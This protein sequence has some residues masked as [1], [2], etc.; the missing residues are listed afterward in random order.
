MTPQL[1]IFGLNIIVISLFLALYGLMSGVNSL[2]GVASSLGVLGGVFIV[3]SRIPRDPTITA[4]VNYSKYFLNQLRVLLKTLIYWIQIYV[5]L[6]KEMNCWAVYSKIP[7][8]IQ[9][10]PGVGFTGGSPYLA[11]PI[12]IPLVEGFEATGTVDQATLERMLR[13]IIVDELGMARELGLTIT[14]NTYHVY[15]HGLIEVLKDY[16]KY[17]VDPYVIVTAAII[18]YTTS[19]SS[20]RVVEKTTTPD[21]V[22]IALRA[23]EIAE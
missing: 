3:Y 20:I 12:E 4:L 1:F 6:E 14:G 23:G 2:I 10:D 18:A 22:V 7:C 8:P 5:L 13:T 11:I 17:P 9:V 19:A 16:S 21:G 15:I